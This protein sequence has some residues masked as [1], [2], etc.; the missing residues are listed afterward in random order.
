MWEEEELGKYK[1]D[2]QGNL[3]DMTRLDRKELTNLERYYVTRWRRARSPDM[4]LAYRETVDQIRRYVYEGKIASNADVFYIA[5][6]MEVLDVRGMIKR[7]FGSLTEFKEAVGEREFSRLFAERTLM[8]HQPRIPSDGTIRGVFDAVMEKPPKLQEAADIFTKSYGIR[9]V[10]VEVGSRKDY[11]MTTNYK[12]K[13]SV[14]LDKFEKDTDL[15][16]ALC[17]LLFNHLCV[18]RSW[19]FGD[20]PESSFAREKEE[21]VRYSIAIMDR[22]V[23]LGLLSKGGP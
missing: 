13:I 18:C 11:H 16:E 20:D 12:G 5:H 21:R 19:K 1:I 22:C 2:S 6:Y 7:Y 4:K 23:Y 17:E 9:K 3:V 14:S 15:L 8:Y 10:S